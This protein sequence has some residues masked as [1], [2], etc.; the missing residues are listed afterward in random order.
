MDKLE[1]L[2][3]Y[4]EPFRKNT[5]GYDAVYESPYGD[6]RLVYADWIASGRLYGP[7]EK[8]I[9]NDFG[10]FVA[11]THTETSESGK[12][13]TYA[14]HH[15]HKLIKKHSIQDFSKNLLYMQNQFSAFVL[16]L[17]GKFL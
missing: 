14:Y 1:N 16:L 6:K 5:I 9:Q 3:K 4:F 11:N 2:E 8:K 12:R 13:M 10:P 7:I 17:L 15:S